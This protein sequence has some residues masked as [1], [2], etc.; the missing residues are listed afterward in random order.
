M[1][2]ETKRWPVFGVIVAEDQGSVLFLVLVSIAER[3]DGALDNQKF[4]NM[5]FAG[6]DKSDR[7][8]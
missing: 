4:A 3:L 5:K 2:I 6:V 7:Y 1:L 8:F